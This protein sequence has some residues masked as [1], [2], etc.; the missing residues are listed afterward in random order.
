MAKDIPIVLITGLDDHASIQ[1]AFDVDATDF[2]T[3]PVNWPILD[4]RV[5]YLLKANE[6]F[7]ALRQSQIR[8]S[9]AQRIAAMGNWEWHI[10]SNQLQ[11]SE[12]VYKISTDR[13]ILRNQL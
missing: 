12:Q 1:Q 8:L 3:K 7:K 5:R 10:E 13:K 6:A 2:I 11:C 9:D 4:H